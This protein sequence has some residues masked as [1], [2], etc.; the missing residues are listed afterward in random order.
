MFFTSPWFLPAKFPPSEPLSRS[1]RNCFL[2]FPAPGDG[3]SPH[4]LAIKKMRKMRD[5]WIWAGTF[6]FE[7]LDVTGIPVL[8]GKSLISTSEKLGAIARTIWSRLKKCFIWNSKVSFPIGM[9]KE[10]NR[11]LPQPRPRTFGT[12]EVL[13]KRIIPQRDSTISVWTED[14][15][16]HKGPILWEKVSEANRNKWIRSTPCSHLP[17][18][19]N[20]KTPAPSS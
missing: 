7:A 16:T 3:E 13:G 11:E 18:T 6:F 8:C 15:W 5:N 9:G 17:A 10:V 19:T 4:G 2:G 12:W 14:Q 1:T 20:A